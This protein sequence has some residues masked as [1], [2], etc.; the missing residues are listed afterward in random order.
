MGKVTKQGVNKMP[1]IYLKEEEIAEIE[2]WGER[3]RDLPIS[4]KMMIEERKPLA[5]AAANNAAKKIVEELE[6]LV[7]S[8]KREMPDPLIG[9]PNLENYIK[10]L[11][12]LV[13]KEAEAILKEAK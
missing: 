4:T 10:N 5:K 13:V 11:K 9:F 1:D 8:I 3:L 6:V 2:G 7:A 12:E